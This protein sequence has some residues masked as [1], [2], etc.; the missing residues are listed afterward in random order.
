MSAAERLAIDV[1]ALAQSKRLAREDTRAA[2]K[3]AAQQFEALFL[4]MVLKAMRE[5]APAQGMFDSEQ[6]RMYRSLLDQQ[7]AQTL[8]ARASVGL[9]ALIEKQLSRGLPSQQTPLTPQQT[10]LTPASAEE[11]AGAREPTADAGAPALTPALPPPGG[12][13]EDNVPAP[14]R[15]FVNRLWPHAAEASRATGIPA[16]FLIA[17]AA[18]E[19]GWGRAEPRMADGTPSHNPFGIKAGRGWR[20]AVAEA[21]TTEYTNGVARRTVE[22]FRAYPSYAEAFRDYVRLLR[23]DPR[24]AAVLERQDAAGFA[25]GLQRAGYASDPM[26]A[27]KLERIIASQTL[28][29]GLM[30]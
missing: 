25:H 8:S 20:G 14:A 26:Y 21:V 22:R 5:A 12:A 16:H 17:Q 27:A 10:P 7:L 19:T 11:G 9:A 2:M 28:R 24:Y 6:T 13:R 30:G 3:Q 18:L 29:E 4:Q 15:A 23:G 1:N